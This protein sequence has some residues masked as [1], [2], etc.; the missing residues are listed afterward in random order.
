MDGLVV[1][2][3]DFRK[4]AIIVKTEADLKQ[5]AN[6]SGPTG[7]RIKKI[8]DTIS[9]S[10]EQII[11]ALLDTYKEVSQV[12]N[13]DAYV[14]EREAEILQEIQTLAIAETSRIRSEIREKIGSSQLQSLSMD[15]FGT[16]DLLPDAKA[17]AEILIEQEKRRI[18]NSKPLKSLTEEVFLIMQIGNPQMDKIWKDVYV[19]VIQDFKLNPRR[20]DKHNEGRFLMSEVAGLLNRSKL[21]I[22]DLTNERQNCYLEVGYVLG[23]EKNS[24]MILCAREDHNPDSPNYKKEG[25]KIHF[26]ISGYDIL[27][28]DESKIDDFKTA[29]AKKMNYRLEIIKSNF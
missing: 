27:F 3:F 14:I 21:V 8:A 26:D 13:E 28:W 29:L 19:P 7:H 15:I 25:P 4:R 18:K 17:K 11:E 20:I 16:L 6:S 10:G 9:Y 24:H 5:I 12:T 1:K 2:K 22:A 23:I